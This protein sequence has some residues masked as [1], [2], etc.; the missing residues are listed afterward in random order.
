MFTGNNMHKSRRRSLACA[1][2][3][4]AVMLLI[5]AANVH[6]ASSELADAAMK[7]NAAAVRSLLEQKADVNAPQADGATALHWAVRWDDLQLAD[8]LIRAGADVHSRNRLGV[9]PIYLACINGNAVMIGKLL[10]AGVNPNAALSEPGETPLMLVARTGNTQAL[11]LLL[12]RRADVN[13]RDAAKQQSALMY[14]AAEGHTAAVQM[15]IA[16]GAD[17][18]ARSKVEI[19]AGRGGGSAP[20]PP[21]P[22]A[23]PPEDTAFKKALSEPNPD[24]R[25]QLLLDFEQQYPQSAFWAEALENMIRIYRGKNDAAKIADVRDKLNTR[26]SFLPGRRRAEVRKGGLTPLL[27]AA[28]ENKMESVRLL[29]AA[30]ADVNLVLAND[31]S[32]LMV[33]IQNAN[34]ELAT[35][36]LDQGADPNL[37]DYDGK[38]ALY[39]AVDMRNMAN[40]DT[41]TPPNDREAA[42]ELI[43]KLLRNGA[44]PNVQLT[45]RPPFRGGANRTWL[46]EIGATPFYR[47]AVSGDATVLRLLL[48]YGADPTLTA[49]DNTTPLMVASGVGYFHNVSFIWPE[50]Q[51]LE[52]LRICM[53]MNRLNDRNDI[54]MTA[55]HGAAF[56]GWNAGVQALVAKGADLKVEDRQGRIA[57][58]WA[59][60]VYRGGNVAPVRN[61][62]TIALLKE[63]MK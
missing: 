30:G 27:L 1:V 52:A 10:D 38:A 49:D 9:T 14:A 6:A 7:K 2:M 19:E 23:G 29:M 59:D 44:E 55:L 47:A 60:G 22:A 17:V 11:R 48:A 31:T 34:Y 53:E 36:L 57:L 51:A 61:L 54:G 24:T 58:D 62:E 21:R 16:A 43:R 18:N 3:L 37:A 41:P 5:A 39:A 20:R 12:D 56:R 50:S 8:L 40:T 45:D 42:L 63:L 46:N 13:A 32:P 28:R 25:L 15:L 4:C 33:A 35:F 26:A